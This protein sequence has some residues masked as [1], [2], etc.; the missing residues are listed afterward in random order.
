[1]EFIFLEIINR[2]KI[3]TSD[4]KILEKN[5]GIKGKKTIEIAENSVVPLAIP[6]VYGVINS[7]LKTIWKIKP[8][9][10]KI[11]PTKNAKITLGTLKSQKTVDKL[12]F[13][14]KISLIF[15]VISPKKGDKNIIKIAKIYNI[16]FINQAPNENLKVLNFHHK[17][18]LN[19]LV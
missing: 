3:V 5:S 17:I 9:I 13:K 12:S 18:Y 14:L 7:I 6:K 16:F 10:A 8:P 4:P 15:I 2:I 1:M 11:E 19:S